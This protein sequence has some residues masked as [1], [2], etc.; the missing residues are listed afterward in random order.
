MSAHNHDE[1]IS[2]RIS[3]LVQSEPDG[4]QPF[5]FPVGDLTDLIAI[6][7]RKF[8]QIHIEAV[9]LY[10]RYV[11]LLKESKE[12]PSL[13]V[14]KYQRSFLDAL[15]RLRDAFRNMEAEAALVTIDSCMESLSVDDPDWLTL[16]DAYN[17]VCGLGFQDVVVDRY[18]ESRPDDIAVRVD[19]AERFES[20]LLLKKLDSV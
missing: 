19:V 5:Y 7:R 16:V 8:P 15:S 11:A 6:S 13:L 17:F 10:D 9:K 3:R 14:V 20:F 2:G 1:D 4:D 18:F 12:N